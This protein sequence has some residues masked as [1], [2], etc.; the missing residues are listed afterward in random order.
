MATTV[1]QISAVNPATEEVIASFD[2]FGR[3]EV[4]MALAETHDAFLEW[5]DRP[6]AERAVPMRALA[7]L[8]RERSERYARLAT[9]EMGK[10][11]VE[12]KA[13]IEKC[14]FGADHFAQNAARYLADEE[15]RANARRS[16][17]AFQPLGVVLA[18][19]PWNFPFW[20]VI[21]FAAPALMAGNAAVLKHASNVPQ[22]ALAIEEAFRDAGFPQGLLRTVLVSGSAIEPIIADERI[23]AVTLTGSSDTGSRIAELA[24]RALK[25]TV[26]ELGGSDPF[27]VLGDADLKL[28]ATTAVRAR[29]QNNGQSCIA[30]KRFIVVDS[31]AEEFERRF[32]K[33]VEDLVVGD[34]MDTKTQ[35]G[36]LARRD[37]L[38][39]L[40]RQVDESVRAG[41][42]VLTGGE[43]LT[44]KGYF[45][46]PTVLVNVTRDMA[47][48]REETF[49]PAAAVIRVR[50]GDEGVRVA[51]DSAYGLGASIWTGDTALGERLARRIESG[52]VFVNG[53]VASDPR[54]PFGGIKR[55]GYGRELSAFGAREFTNIQTIWIGPAEG[56]QPT[57]QP[58]E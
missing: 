35:V 10:P 56:Q 50:D 16:I 52:S 11:I 30:A 34:P 51:N 4:E 6:I 57:S 25:K 22:C 13:E 3:D 17:V 45:F 1:G 55:S 36:P 39:A 24:G 31:V 48:F 49:G 14:A 28:A 47:A 43:R 40:E 27:I 12:A 19:M 20:Q 32:A 38:D 44:G 15:I 26:L 7:R 37:L 23:R 9:L 8:L 33:G 5:R 2:A 18:V 54:L 29:N 53:M 58:A 46:T 21:R 41:A 42:R